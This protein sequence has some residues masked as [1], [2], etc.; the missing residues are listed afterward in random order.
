[1]ASKD[2]ASTIHQS[3]SFGHT[4][5]EVEVM[6]V[7]EGEVAAAEGKVGAVAA[8]L[9]LSPLVGTG[10]WPDRKCSPRHVIPVDSRNEGLQCGGERG[11]HH[12]AGPTLRASSRR[13]L[14]ATAPRTC[15]FWST[16]ISSSRDY[17]TPSDGVFCS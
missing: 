4:V 10:V 15:R 7:S 6:C 12:L 8:Q 2:V 1:V 16:R 13:T 17:V 11:R 14:G 5:V 9:G 3:L